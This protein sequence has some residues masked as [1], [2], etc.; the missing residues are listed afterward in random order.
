MASISQ[1]EQKPDERNGLSYLRSLQELP[2]ARYASK[3]ALTVLPKARGRK[4]IYSHVDLYKMVEKIAN[5]LREQGVRPDTVCAIA[6]PNCVEMIVYFLAVVWIGAIAAPIDMQLEL[7]DVIRILRI[8]KA[9]TLVSPLVDE[10]DV[11][12]DVV[13]QRMK[14]AAETLDIVE[15][16]LTRTTNQGVVLETHGRR[17]AEGAAW[18]GGASDFLTDGTQVA[19]HM[20]RVMQEDGLVLPLTHQNFAAAIQ[21]FSH[22]YNLDE[23]NVTILTRP[24]SAVD[25]LNETLATIYSG[26]HLVLPGKMPE[27][28][29]DFIK[30][31]SDYKV[32]YFSASSQ[33]LT[34]LADLKELD[35]LTISSLKF[36]FIRSFC[37]NLDSSIVRTI[38][39]TFNSSVLDGYGTP[40]TCGI[41]SCNGITKFREGTKGIPV[42]YS[43]IKIL[44]EESRQPVA[45]GVKGSI[46]IAGANVMSGYLDN[47]EANQKLFVRAENTNGSKII[48]FLTG[49]EGFLDDGGFLHVNSNKKDVDVEQFSWERMLI[50]T[51]MKEHAAE[52]ARLEKEVERLARE[53]AE[54]QAEHEKKEAERFAREAAKKQV[55]REKE[56]AK[57]LAREAAEKQAKCEKEEV[58]RLEREAAEEQA[59]REKKEAEQLER[60]IVEKREKAETEEQERIVSEETTKHEELERLERE[61]T[62]KKEASKRDVAE[63]EVRSKLEAAAEEEAELL[64]SDSKEVD[65]RLK[66]VAS[67]NES[68]KRSEGKACESEELQKSKVVEGAES[69]HDGVRDSTVQKRSSEHIGEETV[70]SNVTDVSGKEAELKTAV[71]E[72][73]ERKVRFDE[74]FV[75]PVSRRKAV[76]K[77]RKEKQNMTSQDRGDSDKLTLKASQKMNRR[78]TGTSMDNNCKGARQ[79]MRHRMSVGS[80][81][82]KKCEEDDNIPIQERLNNIVA[83]QRRLMRRKSK[84]DIEQ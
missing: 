76:S 23:T 51:R 66:P 15:W 28:N 46:G 14:Q 10:D 83:A 63:K 19:V 24:W 58:E 84:R 2:K 37:G 78:S 12:D 41:A 81:S 70:A 72:R 18:S 22:S 1:N 74:S 80:F 33:F 79:V 8:S 54:R 48:F 27:P 53:D 65:K 34:N 67:E 56:E 30:M 45:A 7:D 47:A 59:K 16:H 31:C 75:K 60:E 35:S 77:D 50:I 44:D 40:E 5:E 3:V 42:T 17:A 9:T 69:E 6:L 43:V 21:M 52:K 73:P 61:A 62:Q 68:S 20:I 13:Y 32:D 11:A 82:M 55:E 36:K 39:K 38:K 4:I 25:V 29:M 26:G 64:K 71:E 49:D 57:R